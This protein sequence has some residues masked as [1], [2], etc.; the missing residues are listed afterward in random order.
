MSFYE[1]RR[2]KRKKKDVQLF[3]KNLEDKIFRLHQELVSGNYKHS[4]YTSFYIIDPKQRHIHKACVKDRIVHHAVYRILYPIFDKG[5]IQHSYSCRN[6]KG[7]HKAV[8][9][10]DGFVR[11]TSLNFK[12]P[13]FALKCD[14]KKFFDSIDHLILFN[15]IQKKIKDKKVLDLIYKIIVSF[16]ARTNR[17]RERE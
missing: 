14:I 5:F 10:L 11:K 3:E 16:S 1:F 4:N 15:L 12:G 17:E 9:K 6:Q 7:T 13:C 2:G 8:Y